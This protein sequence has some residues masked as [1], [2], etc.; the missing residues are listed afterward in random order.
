MAD[1]VQSYGSR[2]QKQSS[3]GVL[4]PN[5]NFVYYF[6]PVVYYTWKGYKDCANKNK[7]TVFTAEGTI[8]LAVGALLYTDKLLQVAYSDL[9]FVYNGIRYTIEQG[10]ITNLVMCSIYDI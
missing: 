9:Y 10:E 1:V 6:P 3:V 7:I 2:L 4:P 8:L 5:K